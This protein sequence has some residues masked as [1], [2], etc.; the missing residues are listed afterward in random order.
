MTLIDPPCKKCGATR[1]LMKSVVKGKPPRAA[2]VTL[3]GWFRWGSDLRTAEAGRRVL[4]HAA[5][6]AALPPTS[7]G[8][9]R[10]GRSVSS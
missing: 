7:G 6:S 4:Y 2:G 9:C 5:S 3:G 1:S 10:V 8:A